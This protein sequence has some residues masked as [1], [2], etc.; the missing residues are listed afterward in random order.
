MRIISITKLRD[1]WTIHRDAERPLK[2]WH[3]LVEALDWTSPVDVRRNFRTADPIGECLVVFNIGGNRY[4][5]VVSP[6]YE[7]HIVFIVGVYTHR[8]YD[9]LNLPEVER[10]IRSKRKPR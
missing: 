6:H 1:F 9:A 2:V 7:W 10:A 4:R 8:E 5:L 3:G